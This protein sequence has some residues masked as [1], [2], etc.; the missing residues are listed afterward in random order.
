METYLPL[1]LEKALWNLLCL[2]NPVWIGHVID[3]IAYDSFGR[4]EGLV[5]SMLLLFSSGYKEM[6]LKEE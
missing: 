2:F 5:T 1:Q 6:R 3:F 4:K